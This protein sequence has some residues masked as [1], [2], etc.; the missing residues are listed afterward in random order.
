MCSFHRF[1]LFFFS[2][3]K[4]AEKEGNC[5]LIVF[6]LSSDLSR[7][8]VRTKFPFIASVPLLS[9]SARENAAMPLVARRDA[10][11]VTRVTTHALCGSPPLHT[12]VMSG[13]NFPLDS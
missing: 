7:V 11:N 1:S 6:L 12:S 3:K 4:G 13:P 5:F 10:A 9:D 8:N 2:K